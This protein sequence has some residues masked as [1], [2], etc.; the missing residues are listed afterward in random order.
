MKY[1]LFFSL[2]IISIQD[3]Y[4]QELEK[5]TTNILRAS[6]APKIDGVLDDIAWQNAEVANDFTQFR[7]EMGTNEKA[8]QKSV[9]KITFN[10][11]AIF[12][13]AY[14]HD[15]PEDIVRQF[16]SR[17]NFGQS[18]FFGIVINPNNDAQND[19]EF[20]IFPSGNQADAISSPSI[21]EDF[22]WNAVWESA[23]KIV[24]DGW[25]VE[26]KIPYSALRFSNKEAHT[27]GIQF[28]RHFRTDNSQYSW[29]PIDRTKGNIG[30]YH[31]EANG[32][33]NVKPPTRLSF[34][35]FTS[36]V[37]NTFDG[38]TNE[39]YNIG[40]DL[41][42]GI[43][44]NFTLDATLI[45]DFSQ[46]G[47]DN[48][49]LNLGP[50]E[51][52]FSEQRQFFT[53]GVD[54]FTKGDLFYSRR[55][56]N[57]PTGDVTLS[58]DEEILDYPYKVNMLN[59]VKVSGRTKDGLGLGFFNAITEKTYASILKT[60]TV[61][62]PITQQDE[63][64]LSTREELVEPLANYN[65]IVVD[66]QFNKN[67]SISFIN[68]NVTRDGHFRDANVTGLILDFANKKNTIGVEAEIK[69]ST[70]NLE[71]G[72]QNGVSGE[73][74]VG[75]ISGKYQYSLGYRFADDKFD[76]NDLGIKFRNNYSDFSA[77]FSYRIFEP[78][79]KLINFNL[80]A[81]ANYT[82]RF[83]NPATY[84]GNSIGGRFFAQKKNLLAFGGHFN[85]QIG[86]QYDYFESREDKVF[87]YE[88]WLNANAWF[89]SDYNKFFALD[90][91]IGF[92]TLF[93]DGR[94]LFNYDFNVSPRFRF[95]DRFNFQYGFTYENRKGNRGYVTKVNDDIIFGERN[96]EVIINTLT[97]T[98]NFNTF[99][100]LSLTFRNYWTV[101]N[102]DDELFTLLD[103]GELT[104]DSGYTTADISD[105]NVN[106]NT[107]NFDFGYS[108]EFAPGSR[109]TALY[110]NSLLGYSTAS[111]DNY[112]DSL[113][114]LFKEP[115]NHV[116]S[117]KLVYYIDYNNVKNIFKGKSKTI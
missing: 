13:S 103:N 109:L 34:Y 93:E 29:N 56:G 8:H 40:L 91:R 4:T 21:G 79:E 59:A 64:V 51:Q 32:I 48:V 5:K 50:F 23:V 110:R 57:E 94:D 49:I 78:T 114:D 98:Y 69:Y 95:S 116:F 102:Y 9:V 25:I 74:K 37:I 6:V 15:N 105:P 28:H 58:P 107:W 83:N 97:G 17:D 55:I 90:G 73:V 76:I 112:I 100:A 89:S 101:V 99:H 75:E 31:G 2:F 27:W 71:E 115:L 39:D 62:N 52:Q 41:K 16:S 35:P 92:G 14:L 7:P 36:A 113:S 87:I 104:T 22:G 67:S 85:T 80:G 108:W 44:E 43:S 81:W 61:F 70:L 84:T 12:F 3:I 68:T 60:Q 88:N 117:L 26:V 1:I 63:I 19:T 47:F 53:E 77:D 38:V 46:V 33:K 11:N 42:Y 86:K 106:F 66:Q 96:Q 18:D 65:I 20:F 72:N 10:D 30:L 82:S 54:L 24:D 111:S 45:P